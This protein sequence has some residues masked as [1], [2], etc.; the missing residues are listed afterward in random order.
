[1]KK[2]KEVIEV[3]NEGLIKLLGEEVLLMCSNYFYHGKLTGVNTDCVQLENA[4]IVYETG[5]FSDKGFSDIQS[6]HIEEFYV[7]KAS[8]ESFG[9]KSC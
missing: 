3:E 5:A 2:L 6:L 1:M 4:S 9:K 7:Q 8:I